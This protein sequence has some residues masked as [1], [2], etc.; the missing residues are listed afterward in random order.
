MV[1]EEISVLVLGVSVESALDVLE[2][3]N[4]S[5]IDVE[6]RVSMSGTEGVIDV[7]S[8][9]TAVLQVSELVNLQRMKARL[10]V[11]ELSDH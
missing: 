1:C 10:N 2:V 3:A 9:L 6:V 8:G 5:V 7:A 11:L 4:A